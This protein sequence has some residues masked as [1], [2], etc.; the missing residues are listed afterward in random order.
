MELYNEAL[1]NWKLQI[2]KG[3]NNNVFYY[4]RTFKIIYEKLDRPKEAID[5]L[6]S[7]IKT[8]PKGKLIFSYFIAKVCV[9]KEILKSKGLKY[10]DYCIKEFKEN[11]KFTLSE[12]KELK[13]KLRK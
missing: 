10:I 11:R 3:Y 13:T 8:Y 5:F 7:S 1:K 12:A 6:E 9:E 2:E 4:E